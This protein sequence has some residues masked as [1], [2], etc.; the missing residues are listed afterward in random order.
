ML[1]NLMNL[2]KEQAGDAVINNPAVPDEQNNAVL[3]E[4]GASIITGL[5]QML[6][7]GQAKEV[8]SMFSNPDNVNQSNP[9]V[10]QI[11]GNLLESLTG[12]LGLGKEAAGGIIASLLPM[13]LKQFASRAANP[14]D[15][16]FS[17]PEI[18][19][20]LSGGKT[21]GID[22]GGLIGKFAQGGMDRDGDGDVDLNDLT[23]AF[24]GVGS[25][26]GGLLDSLAGMF[27]KK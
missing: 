13:I 10:Q 9:A 11:S 19:G 21:S 25:S 4:T 23:A 2:I 3:Q 7:G 14:G 5:Q 26:G 15:N 22:I 20:Q 27:G 8:I 12:K 16:S 1:E 24:S 17:L 6:A 18:F